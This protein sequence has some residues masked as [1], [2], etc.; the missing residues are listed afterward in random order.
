M[1]S[2]DAMSDN[3]DIQRW[4]LPEILDE[5]TRQKQSIA[6]AAE[7]ENIQKQAYAE[8][9][10]KGYQDGL[11]AGAAEIQ[12]TTSQLE[13]LMQALSEPFEELD[14]AVV[15]QMAELSI[16]IARQLIRRELQ[17]DPGQVIA[18]VREAMTALPVG[19]RNI[20]IHLHPEDA[21]LV[22]DAFSVSPGEYKGT[23]RPWHIVEDPVQ[24][25][26]GCKVTSENSMIDASVETRINRVVAQLFGG[27]RE[28][29]NA[30][31]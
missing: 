8:A 7:L 31:A 10:E 16:A 9:Y 1:S 14:D 18:V 25:R 13:N 28:D 3:N 29:D 24:T 19:S 22:R 6:T 26:G 15:D 5:V 2:S 20:E 12:Q 17:V 11:K 30:P 4:E 21:L 23:E 27:E